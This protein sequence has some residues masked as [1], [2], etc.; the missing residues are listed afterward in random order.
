LSL[1]GRQ[2]WP[3]L[4]A[5]DRFAGHPAGLTWRWMQYRLFGF[6]SDS[7]RKSQFS[8]SR[9]FSFPLIRFIL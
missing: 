2:K 7:P 3:K 4:K 6:L 9:D 8:D 1:A 5:T